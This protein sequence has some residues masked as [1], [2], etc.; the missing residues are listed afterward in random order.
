MKKSSKSIVSKWLFLGCVMIFIQILIGGITRLTDSGLSITEWDI[1][2]GTLPPMNEAEWLA[3]FQKYQIHAQKQFTSLH[4]DMTLSHFKRIFFWEYFHRLWARIMGFVFI[5]PFFY[6]LI[7]KKLNPKLIRQLVIVV[8]LAAL[9]ATFGWIMV[10]SGLNDDSRTWV[11][12]YK[13]LVHLMIAGSLFG[14][15][16]NTFYTHQFKHLQHRCYFY[17]AK[18]LPWI[19]VLLFIQIAFGALMA[20]M[21]AALVFPYPTILLKTSLFGEMAKT[22]QIHSLN[23]LLNYE[24]NSGVKL[25]VQI[26]HRATA[27]ILGGCIAFFAIKNIHYHSVKLF[28]ILLLIQIGL[29]IITI[30]LSIGKIPAFWGVFHQ[31]VAFLLLANWVFLFYIRKK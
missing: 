7:T 4:A 26:L 16:M 11:S 18:L 15:L 25:L 28:I 3:T 14:Y 24:P 20:G 5:I 30:S 6:F 17:S 9:A 13:L 1:V 12:A 10:A 31:G 23:D 22:I 19:G 8:L 27:W 29:G 21:K 2:K